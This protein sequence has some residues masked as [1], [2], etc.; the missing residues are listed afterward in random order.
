MGVRRVRE[1]DRGGA[2]VTPAQGDIWWAE[3]EERKRRPVLVVTRS[4]GVPVLR[5]ILV[6]PVTR[7][8]RQVSTEILLDDELGL[9]EPCAANFD[10]LQLMPRILLTDRVGAITRP[11]REICRALA[12]LADC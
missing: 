8:I 6:A 3:T 11:R 10:N 4:H 7:R 2:L 5:S 9:P 1:N 12:A